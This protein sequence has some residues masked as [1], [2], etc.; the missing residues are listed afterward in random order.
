MEKVKE[1]ESDEAEPNDGELEE[2]N[3]ADVPERWMF[4]PMK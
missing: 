2:T 4:R 1:A 3:D